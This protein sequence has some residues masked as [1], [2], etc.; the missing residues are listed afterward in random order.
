[1][2][3]ILLYPFSWIYGLVV[4]I[5]NSL[6]DYK[7]F[8]STE[9]EIP[10]ISIGN[11]TVGGTGKTPHTEYL[12]ELLKKHVQVATLSRGYKR[13]TKGF[14]LVETS[15]QAR[16]V[17]DE[18][19][20]IKQKF[21]EVTVAVDEKRVRGIQELLKDEANSPDAVLLDDAFQHRKVSPGI[22]ILLID[23]NR[24]IDK[25]ELL[26]VGRLRERKYQ[27]RRANIIVYTKCPDE[28]TPITRRIIMKDVNLRPYQ[29][30]YFTTM[31]YGDPMPVFPDS[32]QQPLDEEE[33]KRPVILLSGIANPQLWQ[34]YVAGRFALIDEL[35]FGD[36]HHFTAKDLKMIEE[37]LAKYQD[38]NPLILTTEKDAMRLRDE[39]SFPDAIQAQFY[40]I[41]LKIKFLDHEGKSFD[42]TIVG[43]VK[44]NRSNRELHKRTYRRQS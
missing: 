21:P 6:Y 14:R 13:K 35:I 8:K 39:T 24:P 34:K 18:P 37:R 3:K 44:D 11:I 23:Y 31:V 12:V 16:E 33:L 28:I 1:M 41:P 4:Y 9:F 15:S 5:R 36:H 10:V 22:N 27:R 17:G 29:S 43:Y 20:Q 32:V 30:L 38:R 7:I 26:P 2:L 42:K 19:L 25:D 40:Y